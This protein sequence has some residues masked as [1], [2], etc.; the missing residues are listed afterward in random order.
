MPVVSRFTWPVPLELLEFGLT[1]TMSLLGDVRLR[2]VP[3][4]PDGGV[5]WRQYRLKYSFVDPSSPPLVV[6]ATPGLG[7][8]YLVDVLAG[9]VIGVGLIAAAQ[10]YTRRR[11]GPGKIH[12]LP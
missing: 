11:P 5:T 8:H 4:S 3:R 9:I 12:S 10:A 6:A 2:D 7:G 1:S